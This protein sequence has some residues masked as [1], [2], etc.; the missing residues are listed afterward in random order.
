MEP[1]TASACAAP[2]VPGECCHQCLGDHVAVYTANTEFHTLADGKACWQHCCQLL[3][4]LLTCFH[5]R[6]LFIHGLTTPVINCISKV[7]HLHPACTAF[8]SFWHVKAVAPAAP[9]LINCGTITVANASMPSCCRTSSKLDLGVAALL[10]CSLLPPAWGC[11]DHKQ[12]KPSLNTGTQTQPTPHSC[13][14]DV[15]CCPRTQPLSRFLPCSC[16]ASCGSLVW[17]L[18]GA[19]Q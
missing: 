16:V 6:D 4:L 7:Q 8:L 17:G 15:L 18:Q 13:C 1:S 11:K 14:R 3:N 19:L 9:T 12:N 5:P 10:Q 2:S